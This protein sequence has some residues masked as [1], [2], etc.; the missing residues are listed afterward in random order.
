[1]TRRPSSL[2]FTHLEGSA[3]RN[4]PAAACQLCRDLTCQPH[5][6]ID[7]SGLHTPARPP[8]SLTNWPFPPCLTL[9]LS[10]SSPSDD[11]LLSDV[12][13]EASMH[14]GCR[15]RCSSRLR[16]SAPLR[17]C[18]RI[19]HT[20]RGRLD[21]NVQHSRGRLPVG[22]ALPLQPLLHCSWQPG[23]CMLALHMA[24]TP[25]EPCVHVP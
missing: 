24:C 4:W 5:A 3:A 10:N 11:R 12:H 8:R 9:Q 25:P 16:H 23:R 6:Y 20:T 13:V 14:I 7:A 19:T 1:M 18:G 2:P 17:P 22:D 21:G 15:P